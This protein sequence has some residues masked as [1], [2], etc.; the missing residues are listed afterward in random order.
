MLVSVIIPV[1]N[2]EEFTRAAVESA[3][4]Q[5]E[6]GEVILVEDG[7]SDNSLSVCQELANAYDKVRLYRHPDGKNYGAG[8][9]RNLGILK[10]KFEFIA[11]LDADDY[12]LP[13]RFLTA[14]TLFEQSPHIDGVYEA[15][16]IKFQNEIA[17]QR[18]LAAGRDLGLTTLRQKVNCGELFSVLLTRK[19]GHFSGDGL[20]I[21]RTVFEKTG[22]FDNLILH[23]DTA[24]WIKMASV[25]CLVP[26]Q[27]D[28]PVTIRRV[29]EH[30]RISA[31]RS[32]LNRYYTY[33]I[34]YKTL[35]RWGKI[36]LD[37]EKEQELLQAYLTIATKLPP[38]VRALW[39]QY[40]LRRILLLRLL[41]LDPHLFRE[42]EYWSRLFSIRTL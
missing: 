1:Y 35:W 8:A 20:V 19:H 5:P 10:S 16:G 6:T 13:N 27:I 2:A 22:L 4:I 29:H 15:I 32:L 14:K 31:P 21:K 38:N 11:F 17:R 36:K 39:V 41:V 40:I 25:C 9:S 34:T 26:G 24:M 30:N 12:F 37:R 3:L 7:S 18:W 42:K 23:E 33:F 28:Q